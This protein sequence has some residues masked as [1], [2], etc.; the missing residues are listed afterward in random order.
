MVRLR[1][2]VFD[3]GLFAARGGAAPVGVVG[4]AVWVGRVVFAVGL[5]VLSARIVEGFLVQGYR[6]GAGYDFNIFLRAARAVLHGGLLYPANPSTFT[7]DTHYVY[8]PLLAFLATP[9]TTV[10]P[11]LA[12]GLFA[13][14]EV[15][16]LVFA[17]RL[18]GVRDWRCYALAII[19]QPTR[20]AIGTGTIGPLLVLAIALAWRFRDRLRPIAAVAVA[21]AVTLKLFLWPLVVWLAVTRRLALAALSIAIGFALAVGSW[22]AIGFQDFGSYP[23]LLTRL[24]HLETLKSY[25]IVALGGALGLPLT[26]AWAVALLLAA[27]LLV[28]AAHAARDPN[29]TARE[30]DM[31]ALLYVLGAALAA[32]PILWQHY[33]ILILVPLALTRPRLTPLW[34]LPLL[35]SALFY[36]GWEPGGWAYGHLRVLLPPL[37]VAAGVFV[38]AIRRP[39]L[40][41]P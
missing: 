23:R 34:F 22:A 8:P 21:V 41:A 32:S 31:A 18:F 3:G 28:A 16:A 14:V 25:S 17:L 2:W 15:L 24:S 40:T 13:A 37:V 26:L 9:L 10:S 4:R 36:F 7:S 39:A 35:V 30:R 12:V 27:G 6:L 29:R 19:F 11:A 38:V 33:F 5:L 20:D 1:F